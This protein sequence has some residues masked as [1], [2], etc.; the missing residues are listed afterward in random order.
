MASRKRA[1]TKMLPQV[2]SKI[3][4]MIALIKTMKTAP[5]SAFLHVGSRPD[6]VPTGPTRIGRRRHNVWPTAR[7]TSAGPALARRQQVIES[8]PS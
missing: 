2:G 5:S 7:A 8:S 4:V 3:Q 1:A 6:L